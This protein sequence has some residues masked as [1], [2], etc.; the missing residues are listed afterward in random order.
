MDEQQQKTRL[1]II[2]V[3][4]LLLLGGVGG[5]LFMK[6]G[7]SEENQAAAPAGDT[8]AATAPADQ[9]Q[10]V[11]STPATPAGGAPPAP[12][13]ASATAPA[14]PAAAP[15]T[16]ATPAA[17]PATPATPAAAPATPAAAAPSNNL[18]NTLL[19]ANTA[20]AGDS[21]PIPQPE[22][23]AT[24]GSTGAPK[25][26]FPAVKRDEVTAE[27][28]QVAGRKDP[29]QPTMERSSFPQWSKGV[30]APADE[31]GDKEKIV[32]PP[33]PPEDKVASA[34]KI[35][36]PPPPMPPSDGGIAGGIPGGV[37]PGQLPLPPEKPS[38]AQFLKLTAIVGNRAVLSVPA[39][40][41]RAN[42]WPEVLCLGPGERFEDSSNGAIS[43]VS[44]DPDSVT[45][46]EDGERS[47]KSLPSIK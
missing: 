36:P 40:L 10:T 33:P 24:P 3:S 12:A 14:T 11:A 22:A 19:A 34:T 17:A 31:A 26:R 41:R 27:A 5:W 37:D 1:I 8:P 21:S 47:V 35:Q 20:P 44:V 45:L 30:G 23:A 39:N 2:A 7:Q 25:V 6:G 4:G 16:P 46:D 32:V 29:M 28:R 42:K 15:A 18:A 9:S 43:V 13:D 38:V